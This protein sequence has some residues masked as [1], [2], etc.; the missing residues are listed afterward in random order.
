MVVLNYIKDNL[1]LGRVSCG[2]NNCVFIV[3]KLSEIKSIV[4]IF[5]QRS[6]NTTKQLNF[7]SFKEAYILYINSEFND[8]LC[9]KLEHLRSGMNRKR[10]DF[11]LPKD[12]KYSITPYWLLGFT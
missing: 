11:N 10:T 9:Y 3:D 7:L 4:E 8:E 12:H 1:G 2:K 5:E 6:L